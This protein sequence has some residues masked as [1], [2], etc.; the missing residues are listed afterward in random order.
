VLFEP[1]RIKTVRVSD[2]DVSVYETYQTKT[3]EW[4]MCPMPPEVVDTIRGAPLFP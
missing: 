2:W 1:R 4:V 3:G